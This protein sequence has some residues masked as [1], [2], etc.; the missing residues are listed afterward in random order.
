MNTEVHKTEF[1][2]M[3]YTQVMRCVAILMV[4]LQHLSG[5]VFGSRVFTPFGGGGVAIFLIISGYGLTLSAKK[6]G[7][8]AFWSKKAVRVFFPWMVVWAVML[9][10]RG[11]GNEGSTLPTL[12]LLTRFN[13]YLQ[14]LL[15]CYAVFYVGHRWCNKYRLWLLVAF[16][17][18]TFVVWGNIQAEQAAS[19]VVGCLLAEREKFYSWT[20]GHLKAIA[21]FGLVAF[22][23]SLGIKQVWTV[24][25]LM[26]NV[27][28]LEHSVNIC[29]KFSLA[30]F[31][32]ALC[33]IA[34]RVINGSWS[35]WIGK[36]SYELYLV[37]L[38]IVV[39]LC[40]QCGDNP[41]VWVAVFL[42]G[43]FLGAWLLY[44]LDNKVLKCFQGKN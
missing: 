16:A 41:M 6:K 2:S 8:S 12:F 29:L 33:F 28:L 42:G 15:L 43:S 5:F 3:D 21:L 32:M 13:W 22:V 27:S 44:M 26:E 36:I 1:M 10:I 11:Y 7:L 20:R 18:V 23:L 39:G 30:S 34:F 14:Y 38:F 9:T 40:K 24:R 4:M 35:K 31:V 25:N 37:H 19:F 17:A